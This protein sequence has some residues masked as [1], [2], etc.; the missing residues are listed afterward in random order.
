M[1]KKEVDIKKAVV[2]IVAAVLLLLIATP[3]V[4]AFIRGW[5]MGSGGYSSS[6]I[7]Y[8]AFESYEGS[9]EGTCTEAYLFNTET[10]QEY[11]YLLYAHRNASQDTR[12]VHYFCYSVDGIQYVFRF[13]DFEHPTV[14][15]QMDDKTYTLA[16]NSE[17][18]LLKSGNWPFIRKEAVCPLPGRNGFYHPISITGMDGYAMVVT[19][20]DLQDGGPDTVA[21]YI[22]GK[23]G[24]QQ[25][26]FI[27]PGGVRSNLFIGYMRRH[28]D[29]AG[30]DGYV[31]DLE[32][33]R[34]EE[35]GTAALYRVTYSADGL[36]L[37]RIR[38]YP[39][40]V[41]ADWKF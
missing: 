26:Q 31:G 29:C 5:I 9:T 34:P 20:P 23:E 25:A 41:P 40:G 30:D 7:P 2:R 33:C 21:V 14:T 36:I 1:R 35:D 4:F 22:K 28:F 17:N 37:E 6:I 24:W 11:S 27:L 18:V 16:E 19:A 3:L 13:E 38:S 39:N 32:L 10:E 12:N 8:Y 15:F